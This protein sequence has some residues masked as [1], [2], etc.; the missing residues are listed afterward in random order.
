V[1]GDLT[2]AIT[3]LRAARDADADA[4]V[5]L[6]GAAYAEYPGCVLD[7]DGV[8]ADLRAPAAE[9]ARRDGPWWVVE[10]HGRIIGSV[11]AGPL[12]SDGCVELKRLYLDAQVRGQGLATA[13]VGLVL[14]HAAAV[15]ARRVDLWS[16]TR[17][18]AAHRRYE[19]LGFRR[20]GEERDLDDPSHTTEY[21]FVLA[22]VTPSPPVPGRAAVD[23]Q[24]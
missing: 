12:R 23:D 21:R 6:I 20:T 18:T 19:Q 4:L 1:T 2:T 16:D 24:P 11:G 14:R 7:L 22:I 17:F 5:A 15:G 8:D 9:A 10:R 3:G 13:L